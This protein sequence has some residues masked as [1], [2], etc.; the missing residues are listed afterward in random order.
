MIAEFTD[1]KFKEANVTVADA[2]AKQ[3]MMKNVDENVFQMKLI[4]FSK[5]SWKYILWRTYIKKI[6]K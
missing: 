2:V 1:R 4:K 6:N 3:N 5:I